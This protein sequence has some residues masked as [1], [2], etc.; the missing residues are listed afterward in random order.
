ML[1]VMRE[2]FDN[3]NRHL[4][5]T[6]SSTANAIT[7]AF[8]TFKGELEIADEEES[9]Q[10]SAVAWPACRLLSRFFFFCLSLSLYSKLEGIINK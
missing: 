2:A 4:S 9:E 10:E 3:L 1:T 8:T 7:K 6:S 5:A